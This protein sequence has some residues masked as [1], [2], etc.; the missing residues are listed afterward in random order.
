MIDLDRLYRDANESW[1]DAEK[2][3]AT[4]IRIC[5]ETIA[6]IN[7]HKNYTDTTDAIEEA[8]KK[9]EEIKLKGGSPESI[10]S[11]REELIKLNEHIKARL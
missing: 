6:G 2:Y 5:N 11:L 4:F 7:L 9:I 3:N 8:T 10:L 1:N